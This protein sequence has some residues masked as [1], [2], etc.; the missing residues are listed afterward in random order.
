MLSFFFHVLKL[1]QN[2]GRLGAAIEIAVTTMPSPPTWTGYLRLW[3][4]V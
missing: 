2:F 3:Q 1:G 4:R